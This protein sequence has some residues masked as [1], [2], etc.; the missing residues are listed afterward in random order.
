[1][2]I[3]IV[4]D[5]HLEFR[6]NREWIKRNPLIPKADILLIAGDSYQL[7]HPESAE[8]FYERIN[9]DFS[10][11]IS[12]MGNHEFYGSSATITY[13]TYAQKISDN[14]LCL[15]NQV[16]VGGDLRIIASILWSYIP[17]YRQS[18]LEWGMNDFRLI[19]IT[20]ESGETKRFRAE[21]CN[22]LHRQ[23]LGFITAELKKEFSGKTVL[24][25][26]HLP[27]YKCIACEYQSSGINSGFASNLDDLIIDNPKICTWVCGH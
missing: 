14:H 16:W 11:I 8:A 6:E 19:N 7:A 20:T 24:L 25:T 27:S 12:T 26:H 1:L 15:N 9:S 18:T 17:Q 4:S 13:P 23:S 21:D 10:Q 2:K 3:Q 22:E 5:L